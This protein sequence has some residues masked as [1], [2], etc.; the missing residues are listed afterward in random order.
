MDIQDLAISQVINCDLIDLKL[1]A[2]TKL[3]ALKKLTDL[4]FQNEIISDRNSFLED[5]LYREEEGAT[6]LGEGI[7]IP[8]GKSA[9]VLKTSIVIGRTKQPIEWESLDDEPVNLIILFAVKNSD[10]TTTHI[11]LLQKVAILLADE[12]LIRDLQQVETEEAFIRLLA[13]NEEE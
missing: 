1:D 2:T 12:E 10:S 13:K 3:E 9:S 5:V 11:K 6:G 8:H 4:L 7:A